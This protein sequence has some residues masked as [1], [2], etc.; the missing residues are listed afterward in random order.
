MSTNWDLNQERTAAENLLYQRLIIFLI[1]FSVFVIGAV[2][3]QR[4]ILFLSI[5]AIG[6]IICWVLTFIVIRTA[7]R[8]DNKSGGRVVRLLLG[9]FVPIFCSVLLTIALFV[10]SFGFVDSYLFNIDVKS[11][12]IEN[13]IDELKNDIAKQISPGVKKSSGNFKSIDSVIAEGKIIRSAKKGEDLNFLYPSTKAVP[14]KQN[15]N[16]K[17]FKSVDSVM[18]IDKP[19]TTKKRT[20]KKNYMPVKTDTVKQ[21]KE[22]KNFSDI[23]RVIQKGK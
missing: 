5:L 13:K 19:G 23:E 7:K 9:Y 21:I 18:V 6:V 20:D 2:N 14:Q 11:A 10:G 3:T 8:I 17:Y 22:S 16:S 4:K 15:P 12:H 1:V